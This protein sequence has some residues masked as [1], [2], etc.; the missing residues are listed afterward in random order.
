S[1]GK[2]VKVDNFK[3]VQINI[4]EFKQFK[5][6]QVTAKVDYIDY[7]SNQTID[8]FPLAS[9]FIFENI[10]ATF[11]GDKRACEDDYHRFFNQRAVAFPS[12]EQMI[13]DSGEDLKAKLKEI[14]TRNRFR[15]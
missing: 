6:V 5:S 14:I 10:Y 3:T 9:E 13:F 15:R 7:R 12:N 1:L 8:T 2:P 4:Y 11:N